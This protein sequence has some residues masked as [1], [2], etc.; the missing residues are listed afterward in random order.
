MQ[1]IEFIH[2]LRV[3]PSSLNVAIVV[4]SQ[5][6]DMRSAVNNDVSSDSKQQVQLILQMMA[7]AGKIPSCWRERLVIFTVFWS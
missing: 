1:H 4:I 2:Q 7:F 3:V 6:T 5:S